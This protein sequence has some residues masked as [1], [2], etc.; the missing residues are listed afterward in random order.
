MDA[1]F[2]VPVRIVGGENCVRK[3]AQHFAPFGQLA[4]IVCGR[5]AARNGALDD[6]KAALAAN[7]QRSVVYDAI[8]HRRTA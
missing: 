6:V 3:G 4:L 5:S 2:Y 8:P 7:G 1:G